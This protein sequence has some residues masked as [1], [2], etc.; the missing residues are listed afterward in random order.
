[1]KKILVPT[2]FSE[3]SEKALKFAAEVALK[4]QGRIELI[5]VNSEVMYTPTIPEYSVTQ[6][7]DVDKYAEVADARLFDMK[8]KFNLDVKYANIDM[9]AYVEEG[10]LHNT[11]KRIALEDGCDLVVMGTQGSTGASEF[12]V[13][14]NTE[15][16]IRTAITPVLVVPSAAVNTDFKTV[17]LTTTLKSDQLKVFQTT[18]QWQRLFGFDVKILYINNPAGFDSNEEIGEGSGKYCKAVGL[19]KTTIYST[20]NVFNEEKAIHHFADEWGADLIIMGTHQRQGV[21]HML[22]GSLT[23]DTANHSKI[24]VLC[25]PLG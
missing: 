10:F 2:D 21:S 15:K 17:V 13:G 14:S 7:D 6:S 12:F 24:P 8:N 16:V 5:N 4:S 25:V 20:T 11:L 1:M 18:A 3:N 22:F 9:E 23:E 19:E